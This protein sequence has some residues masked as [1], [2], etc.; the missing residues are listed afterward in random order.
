MFKVFND[1]NY[2]TITIVF[3]A[4]VEFFYLHETLRINLI[5]VKG[6]VQLRPFAQKLYY[7]WTLMAL[8]FKL[9][10]N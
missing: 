9:T 8:E 10:V 4:K 6:L 7:N 3:G 1:F 2:L 5:F